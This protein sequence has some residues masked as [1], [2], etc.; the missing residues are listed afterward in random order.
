[1]GIM[2]ALANLKVG[3]I[4]S[5]NIIVPSKT[6]DQ[7]L[8]VLGSVGLYYLA[9][10]VYQGQV[11][12][13]AAVALL[14]LIIIWLFGRIATLDERNGY[15]LD[16]PADAV[17]ENMPGDIAIINTMPTHG[18]IKLG[19]AANSNEDIYWEYLHPK[20]RN[21]HMTIIGG[22]GGGKTYTIQC[23]MDGMAKLGITSTVIDYTDG[24]LPQ[25]LEGD[26]IDRVKPETHLLAK[27]PLAINPFLKQEREI[28]TGKEK[29]TESD[30][31]VATRIT[32]VFSS[33]YSSLG[34]QQTALLIRAIE[35]N[36]SDEFSFTKLLWQL[37]NNEEY[38]G[39]PLLA[40]KLDPFVKA[41][42]FAEQGIGWNELLN[43]DSKAQIVQLASLARDVQKTVAEFAL[44]DLWDYALS[45]GNKNRPLPLVLDEVQNLD[46]K[47]GSPIDK[48]IT[49][50]RKFG[51]SAIQ[52]T[53]Y[54]SRFTKSE[55]DRLFQAAHKLIFQPTE[56]EL[57][58]VARMMK[59]IDPED[60]D[61]NYWKKE[62][63]G[64][65]LGQ[66]FSVGM[67]ANSGEPVMRVVKVD[68]TAF[69]GR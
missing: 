2:T 7:L 49:E 38:E 29:M 45:N 69:S 46:H 41:K 68:I 20:L 40:A 39:G 64:L 65:G 52:A 16:E 4:P 24:F 50:G 47:S 36:L 3:D 42:P 58:D 13:F 32:S 28:I 22:S 15:L 59:N 61:E 25:Q 12:L 27:H 8:L 67:S 60:R 55:K 33:V 48:I 34:E 6:K 26:F 43:S 9:D 19:K 63:A 30:F 35:E 51:L 1:M 5:I 62:L 56:T 44:W 23:L 11:M 57:S 53:Q 21:R 14:L 10:Y 18:R 66:C 54:L 31:A 17:L 37:R